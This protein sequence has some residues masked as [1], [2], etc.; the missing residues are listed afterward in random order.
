[1][2]GLARLPEVFVRALHA[3]GRAGGAAGEHECRE[4][5]IVAG[6]DLAGLGLLERRE[7]DD[8]LG[9]VTGRQNPSHGARISSGCLHGGQELGG[10]DDSGRFGTRQ[11]VSQVVGLKQEDRR[12]DDRSCSPQGVVDDPDLGTVGGHDDDAVA[13]RYAEPG[14]PLR[15]P[16]RAIGELTRRVPLALEVQ[17]LVIAVTFE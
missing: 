2:A 16:A 13:R 9:V 8:A 11:D 7:G 10:G 6:H 12:G 3:L 5:R 1:V 15:Q 14:E 4:V 17:R